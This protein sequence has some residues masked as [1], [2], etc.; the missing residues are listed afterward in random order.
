MLRL[1]DSA[2]SGNAYKVRLLL[3]QLGIP[4]ERIEY[5]TDHGA[6]RTSEFLSTINANGRV[7]VLELDDGRCLPES[8]AILWYL[9]EGTPYLPGADG[10]GEDGRW[11]RAQVLQWMFFEQ[12]SH[13][14]NI[15]TVRAWLTH[16][17]EMTPERVAALPGKRNSG[18]AAQ[19]VMEH[20]HTTRRFFVGE[21]YTVADIALYAYTHVAHEG[22]FD[23]APYPAVRA[24]LGR[25][26]AEPRHLKITD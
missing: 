13:E 16:G 5:D 4:F 1:H 23:L 15:A 14:P 8:N 20:H 7:P 25:V 18:E 11:Q 3:T 17:V 21:R 19:A 24:W 12:Y 6:T 26:A 10:H 22:G 2:S 9:A